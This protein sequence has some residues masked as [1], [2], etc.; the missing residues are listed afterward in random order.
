MIT[1]EVSNYKKK[2]LSQRK[3]KA[4]YAFFTF[5]SNF[6]IEITSC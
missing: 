5:C 1:N 3:E 2:D 6:S 4:N